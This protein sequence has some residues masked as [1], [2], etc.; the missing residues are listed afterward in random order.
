MEKKYMERLV[1]KYCKIVTKEPGE[2]RASVVT[3]ILED[4]DYK[5]GFILVDSNQGLGCLRIN[6]IVAI[7]PGNKKR[8]EKRSIRSHTDADV[9]IGTLI[10]FIAMVLVAAVAASVIIQTSETLQQRA[11]SVGTQTIRE[12]SSG[13]VI[14]DIIGY[15]NAN[16]TRINYILI[17]IRPRA[18][19]QDIDLKLCELLILYNKLSVLTLNISLISPVNTG[20]RTVFET[21]MQKNHSVWLMNKTTN[22]T[23]AAIA[24]HDPDA[25]ISNTQG[26][27][28]GDRVYILVNLSAVLNTN[29]N[30]WTYSGLE[31]RG[32]ISGSIKPEIGAKGVFEVTAPAV[33]SKR[34]VQMW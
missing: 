33:F 7:K 30:D 25:S 31:A 8:Q 6:T 11:Q 24:L 34:I 1:G 18:G 27:N 5:D 10:V 22:A 4:V 20:Y 19:S 13:I 32:S 12:V 21:P 2:E 23:F 9:G 28:S 16:K 17:S 3:G 29:Q 14:D 26:I 15:T